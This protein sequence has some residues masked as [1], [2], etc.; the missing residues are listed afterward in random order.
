MDIASYKPAIHVL[1][2][3]LALWY[4]FLYCQSGLAYYLY[5]SAKRTDPRASMAKIKYSEAGSRDRIWADRSVGNLMEQ[6]VPFL[7]SFALSVAFGGDMDWSC[8]L[9][10]LYIAFR[11]IYP[12]A[13]RSGLAVV[14]TI[15]NYFTIWFLLWT[16]IKKLN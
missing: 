13:F 6:S 11:A 5:F 9:G 8:K 7:V 12:V 4:C 2:G 16:V 3:Y 1:F 15:P 10:W 14:S